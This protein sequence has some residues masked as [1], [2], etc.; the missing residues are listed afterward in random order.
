[1]RNV[2]L[3]VIIIWTL[4]GTAFAQQAPAEPS[5][6]GYFI[7]RNA[8]FV[9]DDR[10]RLRDGRAE[11]AMDAARENV[12]AF[13]RLRAATEAVGATPALVKATGSGKMAAGGLLKG[14]AFARASSRQAARR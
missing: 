2:G 13:Q 6:E 7:W 11:L 8:E 12:L 3:V 14:E 5:G 9:H 10:R 4:P 1:M